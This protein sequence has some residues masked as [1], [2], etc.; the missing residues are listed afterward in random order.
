MTR[1][2][3]ATQRR[4][5]EDGDAKLAAGGKQVRAALVLDVQLERVVFNLDGVD[6]RN[7]VCPSDGA[8]GAFG[9]ADGFYFAVPDMESSV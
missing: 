4:V 3:A 9:D 2:E 7:G 5:R 8:G 6:G 1:Q